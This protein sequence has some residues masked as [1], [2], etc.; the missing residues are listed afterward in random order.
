MARR[1]RGPR[2]QARQSREIRP[3]PLPV[4]ARVR[5]GRGSARR[6]PGPPPP[7]PARMDRPGPGRRALPS[8][9]CVWW[10]RD[11]RSPGSH[12]REWCRRRRRDGGRA[13]ARSNRRGRQRRGRPRSRAPAR[14]AAHLAVAG[15]HLGDDPLFLFTELAEPRA[16]PG[17]VAERHDGRW[18]AS[19][20]FWRGRQRGRR[21][22][23]LAA[24]VRARF[25]CSAERRRKNRRAAE[26]GGDHGTMRMCS[27]ASAAVVF[28][29]TPLQS[30]E[31]GQKIRVWPRQ[32]RQRA[33]LAAAK[34]SGRV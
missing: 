15:L 29:S 28:M 2:G 13:R 6:R 11:C 3:A 1:S 25:G 21:R 32:Q 30:G 10:R 27:R 22:S 5:S 19:V 4:P 7:D 14:G 20:S 34:A 16:R 24:E 8:P 26:G 31:M 17:G 18:A 12:R 9:F 23:T 33:R